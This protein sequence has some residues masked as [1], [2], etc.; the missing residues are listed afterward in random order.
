MTRK[1]LLKR[2]ALL[3]TYVSEIYC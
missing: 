3:I 1:S 2:D